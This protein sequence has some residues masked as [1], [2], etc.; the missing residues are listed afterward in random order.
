MFA[1]V[2]FWRERFC[3]EYSSIED[4]FLGSPMDYFFQMN[5]LNMKKLLFMVHIPPF[6]ILT[7]NTEWRET[8]FSR[9]CDVTVTGGIHSSEFRL[10]QEFMSKKLVVYEIL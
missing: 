5:N 3:R 6:S 7:I 1:C 9:L 10:N 8:E 4:K 2:T